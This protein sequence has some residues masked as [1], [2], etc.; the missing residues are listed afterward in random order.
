MAQEAEAHE[1]EA[2]L[3]LRGVLQS[4]APRRVEQAIRGIQQIGPRK[5]EGANELRASDVLIL[6][7]EGEGVVAAMVQPVAEEEVE[8]FVPNWVL[9]VADRCRRAEL[10]I[11]RAML[12]WERDFVT[13]N[14]KGL[15]DMM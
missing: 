10:V 14:I 2:F 5:L 13:Q 11:C 1:K 6:D 7:L 8:G 9:R 4:K 3:A 15:G 12:L